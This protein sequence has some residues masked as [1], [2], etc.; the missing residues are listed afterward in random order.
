MFAPTNEAFDKLPPGTVQSLLEPANKAKLQRILT[1]H[2]VKGD[3]MS[4]A[5]RKM[6]AD[7]GG[8][9][10]ITTVSGDKLMAWVKGGNIYLTDEN[11]D[12]AKVTIADVKQ[13]NGVIH[14]IDTVL[15][16]K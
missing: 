8:K 16:P 4:G 1:Y 6:I 9:L 14:V 11:G 12:K 15:L 13:S 5:L 3:V 7:E 2:V 10:A